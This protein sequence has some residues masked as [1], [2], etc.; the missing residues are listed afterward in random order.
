MLRKLR[1]EF[2]W[3]G[4]ALGD[5]RDLDVYAEN[6]ARGHSDPVGGRLALAADLPAAR[7]AALERLDDLLQ[8]DRFAKLS[9]AFAKLANGEPSPACCGGGSRCGSP[10]RPTVTCASPSNAC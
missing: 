2:R 1:A 4:R 10:T 9:S 7:E 5:V 8:T 3:F 6:L